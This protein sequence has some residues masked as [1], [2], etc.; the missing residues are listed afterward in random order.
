MNQRAGGWLERRR[1]RYKRHH[2]VAF[3]EVSG[4]LRTG[5]IILFHKTTRSGILDTLETDFLAPLFFP[6][7]EFRHSGIIVRRDGELFVMECT[8]E[9]HSGHS[10]ARY[11]T[12]GR[13]VREVPL[14]P[15]L[16]EYT[17][18]NGNAHFGVRFIA[19][20]IPLDALL[21][22]VEEIGPVTYMKA[23]RSVPIFLSQYV[24]PDAAVR[25][26]ARSPS[27]QMMCS[28]FVHRV[29]SGC[30]A[31][32]DFP[33]KLFAPYIIENSSLFSA[34]E[35]VKYSEIVRFTYAPIRAHTD[36]SLTNR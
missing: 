17:R 21:K 9:F 1:L 5:D 20:E 33:S 18:D 6:E 13:G 19:G 14:R 12:G 22:T 32:R 11:P 31:L 2:A 25:R 24:L 34:H 23:H 10:H 27:S 29:L 8:E 28:E 26:V 16:Q 30:G 4:A 7:S 36:S 35:L 15:L 3:D